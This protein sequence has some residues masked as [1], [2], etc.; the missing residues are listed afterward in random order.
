MGE[1]SQILLAESFTWSLKTLFTLWIVLTLPSF[2]F[3]AQAA[4]PGNL[5]TWP[6]TISVS[7]YTVEFL[8]LIDVNF[9]KFESQVR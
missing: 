5:P 6:L 3:Q 1:S 8:G 2:P 4:P 7:V 9:C